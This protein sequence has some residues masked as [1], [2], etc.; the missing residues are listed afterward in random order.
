MENSIAYDYVSEKVL[1]ALRA[2][3]I[4]I[5]LGA[6]NVRSF[7]PVPWAAIMYGPSGNATTPAELDA[8][9]DRVGRDK[10]L[11]ESLLEDHAGR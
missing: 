3:C 11:Y 6:P 9:M 4:P 1:D 10:A 2:G 8:L 5:Y 7:L